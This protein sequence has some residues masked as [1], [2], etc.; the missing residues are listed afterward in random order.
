MIALIG[1]WEE[2]LRK[3]EGELEGSFKKF[4]QA[5]LPS[6]D[7]QREFRGIRLILFC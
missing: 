1:S 2:R 7:E 6:K 3:H 5:T 4:L